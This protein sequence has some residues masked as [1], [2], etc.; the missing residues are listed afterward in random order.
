MKNELT[1]SMSIVKEHG[2]NCA[3][4][5]GVINASSEPMTNSEVAKAVGISFPTAQK[6]LKT[7]ANNNLIRQYV[8]AYVKL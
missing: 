2:A 6:C 8:D 3:I 7:L 4:V 5:L 1:V